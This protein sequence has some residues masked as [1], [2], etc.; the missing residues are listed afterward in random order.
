M[1]EGLLAHGQRPQ[2]PQASWTAHLVFLCTSQRLTLN[3]KA[4][5]SFHFLFSASY[6]SPCAS[7]ELDFFHPSDSKTELH[8]ISEGNWQL[9][10]P[11]SDPHNSVI[12]HSFT[13]SICFDFWTAFSFI[14]S[15]IAKTVSF[16]K[17]SGNTPPNTASVAL[18]GNVKHPTPIN[19]KCSQCVDAFSILH[20]YGIF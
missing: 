9:L 8:E 6:L 4:L 18:G 10:A 14:C 13:G 20:R 19:R 1:P 7:K 16:C 12:L 3:L 17:P 15:W 2:T 5:F 11:S